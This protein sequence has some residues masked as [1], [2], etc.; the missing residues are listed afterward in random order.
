MSHA[1][2]GGNLAGGVGGEQPGVDSQRSITSDNYPYS[3]F[4]GKITN[5]HAN[6]TLC[7]YIFSLTQFYIFL[8]NNYPLF[9]I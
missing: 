1:G 6:Q 7:T 2:V 9:T 8:P 5:F 3:L 4:Q